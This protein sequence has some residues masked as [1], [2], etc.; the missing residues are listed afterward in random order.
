MFKFERINE[1][2]EDTDSFASDEEL[3]GT[4]SS[5]LMSIKTS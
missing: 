2:A 1:E 5:N 4:E 3:K